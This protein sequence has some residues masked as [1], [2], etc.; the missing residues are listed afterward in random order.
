MYFSGN[1]LLVL[2]FRGNLRVGHRET[3]AEGR[4]V[5]PGPQRSRAS[6]WLPGNTGYR[7]PRTHVRH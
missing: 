6:V 2:R 3:A 4:E 7:L 1:K 5:K